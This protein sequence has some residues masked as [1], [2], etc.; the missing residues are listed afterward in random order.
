MRQ[1]LGSVCF[2]NE[3]EE[4]QECAQSQ[5]KFVLCNRIQSKFVL[6]NRLGDYTKWITKNILTT[7]SGT[8]I[9][10]LQAAYAN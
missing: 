3:Q 6:Y 9:S 1:T 5:S 8:F 7:K 4:K 10:P 2:Y